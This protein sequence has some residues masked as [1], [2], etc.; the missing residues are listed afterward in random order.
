MKKLLSNLEKWLLFPSTPRFVRKEE[1]NIVI[2]GKR[3]RFTNPIY[4]NNNRYFM[5][6]RELVLELGGS[7]SFKEGKLYISIKDEDISIN[8][9]SGEYKAMLVS[10]VLYISLVDIAVLLKLKTRW[11]YK[12]KEIAIY[13]DMC[14]TCAPGKIKTGEPALIRFE[15]V[16]AGPPYN[17]EENLQRVRIMA[18]YLY[19]RGMPFHVAWIPRFIDPPNDVDND[20]SKDFNIANADFV[21]TLDYMLKKGGAVGL[22]GYTHQY[23][24]EVSGD[25]TEFNEDRN[26]NEKSIRDRLEKAIAAAE[27]LE[28][29]FEFFESPHYASTAFQQSIMEQYFDYI[30]EPYVGIWGDKVVISPRNNITKYIPTPLSYVSGKYGTE[31]MVHRI[32]K[33]EEGVLASLFYHPS[34]EMEFI[35]F[36]YEE[37]GY[38]SFI[39]SEESSLHRILD[40]L[41]DKNYFPVNIKNINS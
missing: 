14:R 37:N 17:E 7:L 5:P 20:I 10:N 12:S 6:V 1:L 3:V 32:L 19:Y 9:N 8:L 34:K 15:D 31:K 4:F 23:G 40:A 26:D 30:Y 13:F 35:S 36:I 28:I 2:E 27:R 16:T 38:P 29:P 41:E 22:H 25:G 39:Y 11:H 21:F 33:L 24:D 18:D